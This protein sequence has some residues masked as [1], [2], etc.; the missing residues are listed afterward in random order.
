MHSIFG[1][2]IKVVAFENAAT[3]EMKRMLLRFDATLFC[4]AGCFGLPF[5]W[6]G[7]YGWGL[8]FAMLSAID[9]ILFESTPVTNPM[10]P[11]EVWVYGVARAILQVWLGIN[12]NKITARHLLAHGWKFANPDDET[13]RWAKSRW[14]IETR[15]KT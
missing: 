4:L 13:T 12:G 5:F 14:G 3:G 7:L 1:E 10:W 9:V 8:F 15:G 11:P 6:R 2:K